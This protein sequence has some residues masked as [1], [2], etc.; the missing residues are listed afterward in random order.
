MPLKFNFLVN[1]KLHSNVKQKKKSTG[2]IRQVKQIFWCKKIL[3]THRLVHL[4]GLAES[5]PEP[6]GLVVQAVGAGH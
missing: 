3:Q 5:N 2:I 1:F 6:A 4:L